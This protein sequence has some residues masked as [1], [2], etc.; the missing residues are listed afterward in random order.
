VIEGVVALVDQVFPLLCE[1]VSTTDP[2]GQNIVGPPAVIV[3][4]A[5]L[6]SRITVMPFEAS[7]VQPLPSV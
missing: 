3:G 6:A 7:D 2:P 5:G 4:A 1:D